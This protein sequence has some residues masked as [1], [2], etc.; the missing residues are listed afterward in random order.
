[1]K[2]YGSQKIQEFEKGEE[3]STDPGLAKTRLTFLVTTR[4]RL[5]CKVAVNSGSRGWALSGNSRLTCSCA[6]AM[7]LTSRKQRTFNPRYKD[8]W[9]RVGRSSIHRLGVFAAEDIAK[10]RRVIEYT[11]ERITHREAVK[12][13]EKIWQPRKRDE[14][15]A[16]FI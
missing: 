6:H 9:L 5:R 14:S 1:V 15:M 12:R 2:S 7:S 4:Q 8:W 3:A 13:F 11:G 16:I 10:G